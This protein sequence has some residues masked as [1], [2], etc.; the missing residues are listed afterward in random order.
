MYASP[1]MPSCVMLTT[2]A[3]ADDG[4]RNRVDITWRAMFSANKVGDTGSSGPSVAQAGVGS[5]KSAVEIAKH[6]C[7]SMSTGTHAA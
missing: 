3:K 7:G 1:A 2:V 4:Q 5:R 6:H